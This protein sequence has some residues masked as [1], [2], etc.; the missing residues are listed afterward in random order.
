M[1][2]PELNSVS[3]ALVVSMLQHTQ[4]KNKNS[5][6]K[7]G[8]EGGGCTANYLVQST[9]PIDWCQ[10]APVGVCSGKCP[11]TKHFMHFRDSPLLG[12][13]GGGGEKKKGPLKNF[14]FPGGGGG[15]GKK[16]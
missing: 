5:P 12:R 15:G 9:D 6:S 1:K 2:S 13:G 4:N 11:K 3:W 10:G 8:G 16:L 7:G 14:F